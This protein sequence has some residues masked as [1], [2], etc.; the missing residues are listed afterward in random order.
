MTVD[1]YIWVEGKG[2]TIMPMTEEDSGMTPTETKQ[3][4][5]TLK[6]ALLGPDPP[7]RWYQK[8]A[9]LA[10]AAFFILGMFLVL[11]GLIPVTWTSEG[12]IGIFFII[13]FLS[14]MAASK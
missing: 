3:K 10:A 4:V 12:I 9:G 7:L 11:L 6:E 1:Q 5:Q 8:G 2:L 14:A 13:G